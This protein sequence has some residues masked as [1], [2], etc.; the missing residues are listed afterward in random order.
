MKVIQHK[1][2]SPLQI[3]GSIVFAR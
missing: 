1:A 2:A 3:V